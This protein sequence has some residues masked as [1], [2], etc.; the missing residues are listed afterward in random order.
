[1]SAM[2][3]HGVSGGLQRKREGCPVVR[4]TEFIKKR[5]VS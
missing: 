5:L 4:E 1:M 3:R 2:E